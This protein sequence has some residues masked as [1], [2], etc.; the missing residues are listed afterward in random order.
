MEGRE[1][2]EQG[3]ERAEPSAPG[4]NSRPFL[5]SHL[6]APRPAPPPHAPFIPQSV[7]LSS[8][9]RTCLAFPGWALS[10]LA[11][12]KPAS[13]PHQG[14]RQQAL[15]PGQRPA[16]GSLFSASD[17]LLRW[18]PSR[19]LTPGERRGSGGQHL[20]HRGTGRGTS[21]RPLPSRAA[22]RDACALR[23]R[24]CL[25]PRPCRHSRLLLRT[26]SQA[27]GAAPPKLGSMNET[28]RSGGGSTHHRP[29]GGGLGTTFHLPLDLN[30][31]AGEKPLSRLS[32]PTWP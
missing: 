31:P 4:V 3:E 28:G 12:Q 17:T 23:S 24:L 15:R 6:T 13:D 10:L 26:P 8:T 21:M 32:L 19:G 20:C 2:E 29:R 11:T 14:A 25:P 7:A 1:A 27:F 16:S 30:S 18:V 5:C 9:C 22:G